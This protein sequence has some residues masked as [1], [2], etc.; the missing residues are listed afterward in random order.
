MALSNA[1]G[2]VVSGANDALGFNANSASRI[3]VSKTNGNQAVDSAVRSV[4]TNLR[5]AYPGVEGNISDV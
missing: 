2:I 4:T 3:S 5:I 1:L